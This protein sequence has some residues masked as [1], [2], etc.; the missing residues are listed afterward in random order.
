MSTRSAKARLTAAH[1]SEMFS[2]AAQTMWVEFNAWYKVHPEATFDEMES[3]LGERGRGLLGMALELILRQGDLGAT[4]RGRRC[5]QCGQ[6]MIFKGYPEKAVHG[7]RVD[8]EIPRAYYVCPRC[9]AG[10]FPL[11][12]RLRLRRD[13]W[14]EG[15]VRVV[16]WL[17]TTQPS[18][19][20]AA[21]T[22]NRLV[23]IWMSR[24]T[25]WRC[26]GEV[27]GEIEQRLAEEERELTD[28]GTG[29][30]EEKEH[31]TAQAPVAE[32]GSVS[33]DGSM[34]RIEG[35]G[36][37]EVKM[38]S[39]SEVEKGV[40][41]EA[42]GEEG[43]AEGQESLKLTHH[44]Y[45][46]VLGG[47]ATFEPGLRAELVRRR[48]GD[49]ATITTVND[50]ADWIWDL[51]QRYLPGKRVE[52]LDWSHAVQNLAKAG[53]AAWGEGAEEAQAWLAQRK[54]ELWAGQVADVLVALQQLPRRRQE[55]GKAIRQVQEYVV[56]H[57]GRMKYGRFRAEGRPIGSGT[58]ESGAK[59]VV[60]WRM[61]RG[62][63]RWSSDGAERMLA[64]LGE[65]HS[66]RWE[67]ACQDRAQ[68]A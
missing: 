29:A 41:P 39:V 58:V 44:S 65:V 23:G 55:R 36:Y 10:F 60:Q 17:G 2:E 50:G 3:Y 14:S 9:E 53:A 6:E 52:V 34:I 45:R 12:R 37:R 24:T 15:L 33:I 59:N 63:Q 13:G 4:P 18:F 46:A 7:L 68:A 19:R 38:V 8:T 49:V 62:G 11:D 31:V 42:V 30:E 22:V 56:H 35:E 27:A 64:A 43:I 54:T 16:A 20:I 61:R 5:E 40:K 32:H 26:H 57:G 47:K 21:E 66:G 48:V 51:A 25:L 1:A 28:W 67:V